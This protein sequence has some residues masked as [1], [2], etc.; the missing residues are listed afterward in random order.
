MEFKHNQPKNLCTLI[1]NVVC[2]RAKLRASTSMRINFVVSL[3]MANYSVEVALWLRVLHGALGSL[4]L[5]CSLFC[6][7]TVILIVSFNKKLHYPSVVMSLGL[8]VADLILAATWIIQV[9]A[10]SAAGEWPLGVGGCIHFGLILDW[11][12]C[13]RW[14]EIAVVT[15]DRFLIVVFPFYYK[16][17]SKRLL[18]A[19]TIIA[20]AVP[21][22]LVMPSAFGVG[23]QMFIPQLS[24]CT[25]DCEGKNSCIGFYSFI[26]VL[27]KLVGGVLPMILYTTMYCIGFRKRR[28]HNNRRLG[29]ISS[30]GSTT[31]SKTAHSHSVG[32]RW[33]NN[34]NISNGQ[35]NQVRMDSGNGIA[36]TTAQ[37]SE[38][39]P[40]PAELHSRRFQIPNTQER[41]ALITIFIIFI[42][43]ILT[44]APLYSTSIFTCI[45]SISIPIIVHY[46]ATYIFL[47]GVIL[48]SIIIM[49]NNDFREVLVRL[50]RKCATVRS[51]TMTRNGSTTLSLTGTG[52]HRNSNQA[53][54]S[55]SQ[56]DASQVT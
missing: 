36:S 43:M 48:D 10:Y 4:L 12:L 23:K 14:S 27:L 33:A 56:R 7:C 24:A 22:V 3:V 2:A 31:A 11:M 17:F 19:M 52:A 49:R 40:S 34:S 37:E 8:V 18:V 26:F 15:I 9:I 16:K 6:S 1:C 41:N 30:H 13:V 39:A 38:R 28:K 54:N 45:G 47:V 55:N 20:W 21:A 5:T 53:V 51:T 35:H 32:E 46:T 44:H 42:S 25:V 50:V 29:T